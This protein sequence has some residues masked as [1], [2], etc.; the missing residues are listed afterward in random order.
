MVIR[1]EQ[2]NAFRASA[3]EAFVHREVSRLREKYT[4]AAMQP[5][6]DLEAFVRSGI[7]LARRFE[8]RAED[9]L[10]FFLDVAFTNGLGFFDLPDV[11]SVLNREIDETEKMNWVSERLVFGRQ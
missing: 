7:A 3:F 6:S 1:T 11:R 5:E 8:I 9:N 2:F 10:Q 4:T